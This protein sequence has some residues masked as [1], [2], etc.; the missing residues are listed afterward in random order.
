MNDTTVIDA[1]DRFPGDPGYW[2]RPLRSQL[3]DGD[4]IM[5][6]MSRFWRA[7]TEEDVRGMFCP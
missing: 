1:T 3:P 7:Y 4:N 2:D 6:C 5:D